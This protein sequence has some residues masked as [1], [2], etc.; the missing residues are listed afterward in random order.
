ME[1]R[2]VLALRGPNY[3]AN[4]PVLEGW[5]DLGEFKDSPSD[6][7]PGFN[8][9]LMAWLP[10]MIE[11]RCSI[12]ERGG[13]FER[14]R[15]GTWQGHIIEHVALELQ[16]LA[17]SDVGFGR[18]RETLEDGVYKV[19]VEFEEES[20]GRAALE[21]ARLLCLAAI[22]NTPFDVAAE[23]QTLRE[24]NQKSRLGPSTASIVHA[25]LAR[26]IPARRLNNE[27][28][29]QLG[30]GSRQRR[31][32]AAETD[33]TG[34]I[35][36][37]IAQDKELTRTLLRSVGVPVPEGRTVESADDAWSAAEKIGL[38]VVVKPQYGNQG[39]GVATNLKTR[40]QVV[41][42]YEA[43]REESSHIMVEQFAPGE[44]YRLLVVGD[45]VVAA[46]RR[47]PAM[48]FGDGQH[49]INE[50]IRRVNED[51]RR[52]DDHATALSKIQLDPVALQ[53]LAAQ[54]FAPESIPPVGSR[55]LIRR[56]ANLSTGGTAADVTDLVHPAVAERA[57]EAARVVGLDI[58]GVDVVAQDVGRPLE[59]QWGVIV[60]VNAAPGLRMHLEPSSGKPRPVG[61][62]ILGTLFAEG[63]TGRI[64]IVA[65]TG[66]NG[67]TTTTRF[68]G[69]ILRGA[70]RRV[71]MT[72]TEGIFVD[73]RRIQ[74]GDCSGP[75]S[76]QA[77]LLNP[78][79]D[80]AVLETARGGILRAGLGFDRCDVAVVTNIGEGDHLGLNDIDTLEKLARVKRTIVEALGPSGVAVLNAQDQLVA[81]MASYCRGSVVFFSLNPNDPVVGAHRQKGG[82]AV[83]VRD[84][85][86]L[87]CE[88]ELEVPLVALDR[89]PLAH[90]GRIG[91]QVENT[92]ASVGAAW[93][94][95]LMRD[96][97]RA[98]LETFTADMEHI[99]GRFNLLDIHGVTVVV[100]YGHNPSSLVALIAALDQ[101][102]H[103]RRTAVYTCAG[104]RRDCDMIRQGELLG[105]AFDRII[106]YEDHYVRGRREGEIMGLLQQGLTSGN[107]VRDIQ[108]IR[109]AVTAI[110]TALR[111]VRLGELLMIQ[112]DTIDE[113]VAFLQHYLATHTD[114]RE[115]DLREALAVARPVAAEASADAAIALA[116]QGVD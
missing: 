51:P 73:S 42:A 89:V 43:A 31:I 32:L 55:V 99:P 76:A 18:T 40:E 5:L 29:V 97:I 49:S 110:E 108:E 14:L 91:F 102:P 81:D 90:G 109:G 112:A 16:T 84:G 98:G 20:L 26:G 67:K 38:P 94:L 111:T 9:R 7:L 13:F 68:I 22:H 58:A 107:R 115:I 69:H 87:L 113:T 95:G 92:L 93:G 104:D 80:A 2:K 83:I 53:V 88:R 24:V 27:S 44:D 30:Y 74:T 54:G 103:K 78:H 60:E 114:G 85:T 71:G 75:Q 1:F 72:C 46:A 65:V 106:L 66:V 59:E 96:A 34:A 86:I 41:A 23:V 64:P 63:E 82:R 50:L 15:R 10:T 56:N 12:G 33:R 35:A 37:A 116:V 11:H 57:V 4:F 8:E 61:E 25:A 19:A 62:A 101:F 105:A 79:V 39:R 45:R 52:G 47:E 77:V 70:G 28:L 17:G 100:D 21:S 48:V 3:W 6:Q 36:E